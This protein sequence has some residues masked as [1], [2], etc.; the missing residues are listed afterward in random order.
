MKVLVTGGSGFLGTAVCKLLLDEN[1]EVCSFNRHFSTQLDQLKIQQHLGDISIAEDVLRAAQTVDA[2]IHTAAKTSLWGKTKEYFTINVR[3]T[4]NVLDACRR[5]KISKLVYTSSPSVVHTGTDLEG[6]DESI[7]YAKHFVADYPKTKA[8]AE[9]L[10]LAANS[11]ALSTVALRPHLIWG[12]DDPHFLPRILDR[13]KKGRLRFV[14][15]IPKKIDTVFVDNAAEAHILA[16]KKL[17]P[18]SVCAGK[19]YFITQGQPIESSQ[20]I[21]ALL[22]VAGLP[23]ETRHIPVSLAQWLAKVFEFAYRLAKI[24][25]EPPLTRFLVE[26]LSTAHWFNIDAA[27]RELGYC[28]RVSF[29]EGIARLLSS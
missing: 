5:L 21:N 3:G 8:I 1:Y 17:S 13:A 6:V 26:Q 22:E 4:E 11:P 24:N 14:G 28:P 16:L 19:A 9:Q 7:S 23:S 27:R 29:A 2:V 10:V 15:S 20:M 18:Q 12:P 25:T